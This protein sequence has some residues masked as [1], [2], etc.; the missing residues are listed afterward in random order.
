[1]TA[2]LLHRPK[3]ILVTSRNTSSSSLKRCLETTCCGGKA[4]Q[5]RPVLISPPT[6]KLKTLRNYYSRRRSTAVA[7]IVVDAAQPPLT[8]QQSQPFQ[9][10]LSNATKVRFQ[11][12]VYICE[13]PSRR[14]YSKEDKRAIWMP[15]HELKELI[16]RNHTEFC[17]EGRDWRNAPEEDDFGTDEK[18]QR[19][20][21]AHV[22]IIAPQDDNN[23]NN[24]TTA[25][26]ATIMTS[27]VLAQQPQRLLKKRKRWHRVKALRRSLPEG[28]NCC[29]Q[30]FLDG[31]EQDYE[32]QQC[33][34]QHV[35]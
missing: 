15:R 18:G 11:S 19:I 22:V 35:V 4:Q 28:S 31:M 32:Q 13:I 12:D 26:N 6:G 20:H 33:S 29:G 24:N 5:K 2:T 21:P 27:S 23:N 10:L 8:E 3:G 1:M 16:R 30:T 17:Y 14:D 9:G 7:S 25:A 34:S